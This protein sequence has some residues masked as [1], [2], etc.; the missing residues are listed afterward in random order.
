MKVPNDI[1]FAFWAFL[2]RTER[3]LLTMSMPKYANITYKEFN[4]SELLVSV[5]L[6]KWGIFIGISKDYI[7]NATVDGQ[8]ECLKYAHENGC[9]WDERTCNFAARYGQL[10]CLKYAHENGCPWDRWTCSNAAV[11][12]QLECLKYAHENGC[13]WDE[14]T[15]NFAARY[16]QLECLKYAHEN[17]CP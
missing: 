12:G 17:G 7:C 15:C 14:R 6:V 9:P 10:D 5:D 8:L 3:I 2:N 11:D 16:G 1:F 4:Y 13:P